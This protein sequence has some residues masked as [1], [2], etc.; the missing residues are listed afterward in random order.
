MERQLLT[1]FIILILIV[2]CQQMG[3]VEDHNKEDI[4]ESIPINSILQPE[5]KTITYKDIWAYILNNN[6]EN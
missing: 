1:I 4:V 3:V 6:T 2:G 5:N